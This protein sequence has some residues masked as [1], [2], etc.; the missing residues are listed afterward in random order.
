VTS[1]HN[2]K[3]NIA[4]AVGYLPKLDALYAVIPARLTT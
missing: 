2:K 3:A 4:K 1:N